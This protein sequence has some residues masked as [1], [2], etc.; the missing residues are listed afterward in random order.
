MEGVGV[1]LPMKA[2][3]VV[4]TEVLEVISLSKRQQQMTI[5]IGQ[6]DIP[7][8]AT[9]HADRSDS[10]SNLSTCRSSCKYLWT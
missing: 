1:R 3:V 9:F 8:F 5:Q 2:S 10:V 7:A 6:Q 4:R